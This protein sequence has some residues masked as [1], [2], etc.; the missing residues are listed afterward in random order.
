MLINLGKTCFM[1]SVMQCLNSVTPLK[2]FTE[3]LRP[4]FTRELGAVL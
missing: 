1:N 2:Y 3:D 4:P